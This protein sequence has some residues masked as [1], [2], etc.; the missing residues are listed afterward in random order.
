MTTE[1]ILAVALLRKRSVQE[2]RAMLLNE[3]IRTG[4]LDHM[5]L[6]L[7]QQYQDAT[8]LARMSA[9]NRDTAKILINQVIAMGLEKRRE[10]LLAMKRF[11]CAAF[12]G[13]LNPIILFMG[14]GV[15]SMLI[16]VCVALVLYF[17]FYEKIFKIFSQSPDL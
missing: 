14:G 9:E 4:N 2:E 17:Y 7:I 12:F 11:F 5:A 3:G 6:A 10:R 8:T 13:V 15:Y 1:E 16:S